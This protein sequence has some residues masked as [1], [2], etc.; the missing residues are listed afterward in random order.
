ML[1]TKPLTPPDAHHS[2][3]HFNINYMSVRCVFTL[4][5]TFL[6]IINNIINFKQTHLSATTKKKLVNS[7]RYTIVYL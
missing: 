7:S 3:D 1:A 5:I 2:G 4:Q 6:Y